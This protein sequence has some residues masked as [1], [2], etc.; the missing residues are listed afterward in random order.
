MH[1][2]RSLLRPGFVAIAA[3]IV[4]LLT[5]SVDTRAFSLDTRRWPGITNDYRIDMATCT[6]PAWRD[7][8]NTAATE[9]SNLSYIELTYNAASPN[10]VSCGVPPTDP[11]KLAITYPSYNVFNPYFLNFSIVINTQNY[12]WHTGPGQVFLLLGCTT[13]A[14]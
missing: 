2:L 8:I 5:Y 9:W 10:V 1:R 7:A 14:L 6:N 13:C 12:V 3:A 4:F 11:T